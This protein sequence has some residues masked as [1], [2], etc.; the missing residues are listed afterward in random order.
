MILVDVL[1]SCL[2]SHRQYGAPPC[3]AQSSEGFSLSASRPPLLSRRGAERTVRRRPDV[4]RPLVHRHTP[5]HQRQN[6]RPRT[7]C[8]GTLFLLYA[9]WW[10]VQRQLAAPINCRLPERHS[11][12]LLHL[13]PD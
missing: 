3:P 8:H 13:W 6:P 7:C 5:V 2:H 1:S 12:N 9:L 4:T 10:T 11:A